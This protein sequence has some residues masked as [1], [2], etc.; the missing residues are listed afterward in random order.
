MKLRELVIII[1]AVLEGQVADEDRDL[2]QDDVAKFKV[3]EPAG[4]RL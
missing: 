3:S 4:K 2:L 1:A